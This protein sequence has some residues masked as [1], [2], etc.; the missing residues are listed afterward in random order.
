[1]DAQIVFGEKMVPVKLPENVWTA[2][3]DLSTSLSPVDDIEDTI[4][5]A[6]YSPLGRPPLS[7]VAKPDWKVT[8]AFDD[9]T[10][11]CFAPVWEPAIK[12][13][14]AELE[15]RRAALVIASHQL[16][17][18]VGVAARVG[19]MVQ[20]ELAALEPIA[21]RDAGGVVSRYRELVA[22]NGG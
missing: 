15:A 10:V 2:P 22:A 14:I 6:L 19:F 5:K 8:I 11:P 21:G 13:V 7:E 1:M 16:V 18:L 20:G 3:Q 17:E 12:H 9:P 4:R